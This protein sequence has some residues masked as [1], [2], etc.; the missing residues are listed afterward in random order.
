MLFIMLLLNKIEWLDEWLTNYSLNPEEDE[1]F[2]ISSGTKEAN[3]TTYNPGFQ[4]EPSL[5]E[6]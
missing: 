4:N 5:K 6:P 1:S 3:N 2:V